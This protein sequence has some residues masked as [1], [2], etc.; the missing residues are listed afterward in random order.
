MAR[1]LFT[2]LKARGVNMPRIEEKTLAE[3]RLNQ[4]VITMIDPADI[5][6]GA[7]TR[8]KNTTVRFD[9]TSRRPGGI[10]FTPAAPDAFPVL[11]F[12]FIKL[13]DGSVFLFRFT[14][15]SIYVL[16]AGVWVE[17]T[18]SG[19]LGTTADRFEIVNVLDTIVFANNGAN[20][21]QTINPIAG[22]YAALGNAPAYRHVTG[23]F[24]RAVGAALRGSSEVQVG[25]SADG[26]PTEW[27]P[28][29]DQSAGF[30]DILESPSDL[31]DYI[32]GIFGFTNVMIL[33]REQ[34]IW[35]A[36]KQPIETN[37][38]HFSAVFPG[39]GCDVPN[40]VAVI[41]NGLAWLD[42]RTG[43]VW[44]YTP[45]GQP[46]PIG[47]PI[48][49][50][51][52]KGFD[53]PET[54]FG[55]YSN[56]HAEYEIAIPR[57]GSNLVTTWTYNF[58]T[59]AWAEGE[60]DNISC[61]DDIEIVVGANIVNQLRIDDLIGTID[62]L[63]GTIDQLVSSSSSGPET[64]ANVR[65]YGKKNGD[66]MIEDETADTDAGT[67][68]ETLI[69]SKVYTIPTNDTYI[70][71]LRIEFF[72]RLAGGFEIYW[73]R[74]GGATFTLWRTVTNAQIPLDKAQLVHTFGPLDA[75]QYKWRIRATAG[76]F[77]L[78]SYEIKILQAGKSVTPS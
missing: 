48:E 75:R 19:L 70:A 41:P 20:V 15:E 73:S 14:T 67:A 68:F 47:R 27:D 1:P 58:R 44:A 34:S 25:W 65:I 42:T 38:F 36:T 26:D 31:S 72:K 78:L 63:V 59:K 3:A 50:T 6:T 2:T 7:L 56:K 74:D 62:G 23:F 28:G 51:I 29:V 10:L 37:P 12:I 21:I 76:A 5:P 30:S 32:S 69:D 77:D 53:N 45:G 13:K 24:N 66:A 18:G 71:E 57:A 61:I 8:A 46:E 17:I 16:D 43:T 54:C 4:G 55:S 33:L 9:K 40:S 35:L 52:L 22:T 49:S 60:R 11:A 64:I 39:I